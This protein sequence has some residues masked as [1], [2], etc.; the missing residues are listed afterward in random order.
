MQSLDVHNPGIPDLQFVLLVLALSTS[1]L[2]SLNLSESV[3]QTLFNRC[4]ALLH[5]SSPPQQKEERILDLRFGNELTLEA[6]VQVIQRTLTEQ[7]ISRLTWDH[8]PSEPSQSTTPEA[9]P[10]VQRLQE[11]YPLGKYP[12]GPTKNHT[13]S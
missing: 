13:D 12:A 8:P 1:D 9:Q 10:L 11:L 4:W 5:K 6:L 3:R 7:G 2:D